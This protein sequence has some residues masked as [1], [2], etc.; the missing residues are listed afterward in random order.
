MVEQTKQSEYLSPSDCVNF[1][2]SSSILCDINFV[3]KKDIKYAN[4]P[5]VFDIEASSFYEGEEKRCT[6]YAWV[7]GINGRCTRGRTWDE[8]L[9]LINKIVD[10]YELSDKRRMI[11]YVHNLAYELQ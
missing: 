4:V 1:Q 9:E 7:L 11:I 6:M 2:T 10:K 8:F 5:C 3:R